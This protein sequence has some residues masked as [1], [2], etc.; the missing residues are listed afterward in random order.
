MRR[1]YQVAG[2]LALALAVYVIVESRTGLNY[3]TEYGPGP[4]FL[5]FWCGV[6][7]TGLS[8]AWLFQVSFRA[9]EAPPE[10]FAPPR[11]ALIRLVSVMGALLAF[12]LLMGVVGF[13]LAMLGFLWFLLLRVG[14]QKHLTAFVLALAGS[15][16]FT[17]LFRSRLDVPLPLSSFELLRNLGL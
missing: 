16:A 14:G 9:V 8:A 4:G 3:Y 2:L 1:Y 12:A 13:Q 15:A 17:Y 11:A 5:P 6:L 7:L 10:G